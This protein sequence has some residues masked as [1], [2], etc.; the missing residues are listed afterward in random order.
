M[1]G[2]HNWYTWWRRKNLS[3]RRESRPDSPARSQVSL[4]T[5]LCRLQAQVVGIKS[6][7]CRQNKIRK[8]TVKMCHLQYKIQPKSVEGLEY[9]AS[10]WTW[11]SICIHFMQF[12]HR[13]QNRPLVYIRLGCG[14]LAPSFSGRNY[15]LTFC[16]HHKTLLNN[17]F[18]VALPAHSETQASYSLPYSFFTDG[19]TPWTSDHL[20]TGQ[21]KH[22]INAYTPQPSIPWMGWEPTI[23]AS[24]RA[25]TVHTLDRAVIVTGLLNNT[26]GISWIRN[27]T[28]GS[29]HFD[30]LKE[31]SKT[32]ITMRRHQI[33][34]QVTKV[35]FQHTIGTKMVIQEIS[36]NGSSSTR[37][38]T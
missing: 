25:K 16:L 10:E 21:H 30:N 38:P 23:P 36:L 12:V 20:N 35:Y 15:E 34:K 31:H 19:R 6:N 11:P 2:P 33:E 13:A 26:P 8:T 28:I 32:S 7:R 18:T 17:F 14:N 24:E 9:E 3:L 37:V 29:E 4:L 5:N 1:R 27:F 22:R